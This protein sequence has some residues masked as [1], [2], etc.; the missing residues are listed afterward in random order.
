ML[1]EQLMRIKVPCAK[2]YEIVTRNSNI[3][4]EIV[5]QGKLWCLCSRTLKMLLLLLYL[6]DKWKEKEKI[7]VDPAR[8]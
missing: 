1:T 8:I 4:R 7:L 3:R 5:L 2:N 6:L